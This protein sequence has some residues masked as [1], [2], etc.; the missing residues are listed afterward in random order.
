MALGNPANKEEICD[1]YSPTNNILYLSALTLSIELNGSSLGKPRPAS[2]L[3]GL[4]WV[5]SVGGPLTTKAFN[6]T[7]S[8]T[9]TTYGEG[10]LF[11]IA[12]FGKAGLFFADNNAAA[13]VIL[14]DPSSLFSDTAATPNKI[15]VTRSGNVITVENKTGANASGASISF[16]GTRVLSATNPA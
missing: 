10:K 7:T 2:P 4:P 11:S 15:N 3:V 1:N 6:N 5:G 12:A 13:V 14:S 8:F 9:V 16:I